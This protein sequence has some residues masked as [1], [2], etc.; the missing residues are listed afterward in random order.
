[1]KHWCEGPTP[2]WGPGINYNCVILATVHNS[3]LHPI[4]Q[5]RV[6][7]TSVTSYDYLAQV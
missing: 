3:E 6:Y 7:D 5:V 2:Y 4:S 1:M